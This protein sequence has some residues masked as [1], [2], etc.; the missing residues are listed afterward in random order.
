MFFIHYCC[1]TRIFGY[2][3]EYDF[4]IVASLKYKRVFVLCRRY[5]MLLL[6]SVTCVVFQGCLLG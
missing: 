2:I 4:V 5:Y 3:D 1:Y 6:V